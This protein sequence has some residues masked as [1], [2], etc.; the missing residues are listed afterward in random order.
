MCFILQREA[1]FWVRKYTSATEDEACEQSDR[2]LP[3][4]RHA[5][6]YTID[7]LKSENYS[8]VISYYCGETL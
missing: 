6:G 4:L 7:C 5:A 1:I 8:R 2:R 3:H